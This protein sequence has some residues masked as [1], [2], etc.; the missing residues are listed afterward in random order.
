M[1]QD[2]VRLVNHVLWTDRSRLLSLG[3]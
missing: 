1:S 2:A 3:L